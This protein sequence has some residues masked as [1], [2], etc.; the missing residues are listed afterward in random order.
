MS[1]VLDSIFTNCR[2]VLVNNLNLAVGGNGD[3]TQ[4]PQLGNDFGEPFES[5]IAGFFANGFWLLGSDP[6]QQL[7]DGTHTD[8]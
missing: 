3:Y 1:T 6:F 8:R 4:L 5:P 7:T 2:N